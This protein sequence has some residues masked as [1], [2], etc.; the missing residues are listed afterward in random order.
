M[1]NFEQYLKNSGTY[2]AIEATIAS[3]ISTLISV[4]REDATSICL[5]VKFK[6][7]QFVVT[8]RAHEGLGTGG[9]IHRSITY[10]HVEVVAHELNNE[11][12]G[13]HGYFEDELT[14]TLSTDGLEDSVQ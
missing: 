1:E 12:T 2:E 10:G 13:V 8:F 11:K 14:I 3:S 6:G 5:P 4:G 9:D 7:S